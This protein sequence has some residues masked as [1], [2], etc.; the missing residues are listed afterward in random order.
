MA[1]NQVP[2][3]AILNPSSLESDWVLVTDARGGKYFVSTSADSTGRWV[4]RRELEK[5]LGLASSKQPREWLIARNAL[6]EEEPGV[7]GLISSPPGKQLKPFAR[8]LRLLRA[9]KTDIWTIFIF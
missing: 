7:F 4:P 6:L 5:L 1:G 8:L 9:E 2:V 3:G